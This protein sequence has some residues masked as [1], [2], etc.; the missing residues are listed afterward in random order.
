MKY[1]QVT[2]V[3]WF[4]NVYAWTASAL[5][6]LRVIFELFAAQS[7]ASF[8]NW[9][10]QNSEPL[11]QPFREVYAVTAPNSGHNLDWAA[12]FA[13]LVYATGGYVLGKWVV[14]RR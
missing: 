6:A 9:V 5:L 12:L 1:S 7:S 14:K 13:V 11:L 2:V 4:I 8:V 3:G 10:Y